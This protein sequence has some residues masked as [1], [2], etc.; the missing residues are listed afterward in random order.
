MIENEELTKENREKE[1]Q[2]F[3]D[4]KLKWQIEDSKFLK[5]AEEVIE[6]SKQKGR[7]LLPLHRVVHVSTIFSFNNKS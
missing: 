6:E 5:Y 4:G 7:M 3:K 2:Q 1:F